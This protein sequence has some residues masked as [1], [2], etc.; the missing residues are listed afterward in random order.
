MAAAGTAAGA[1]AGADPASVQI[2]DKNTRR[3]GGWSDRVRWW[4]EWWMEC[5]EV[6][7]VEE[8]TSDL[9]DNERLLALHISALRHKERHNLAALWRTHLR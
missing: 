2:R 5:S 7:G 4:M 1:A 6:M 9:E 8:L 3:R